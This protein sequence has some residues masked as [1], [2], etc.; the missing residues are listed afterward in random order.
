VPLGLAETAELAVRISLKDDLSRGLTGLTGKINKLDSGLGRAGKGVGQLGAGFARA[1]LLVGGGVITGLT[2][3][4]K[5]GADF[6]AQL[7][8]INTIARESDEGLLRIGDGIRQLAR[9]GRGD[10]ADLSEG[11]YD[12]LSAGVKA[13]DA[14]DVLTAATTLAIG[15]LSTNAEAVDLLTTAINAY[16]QDATAA[17]AD[18]DLFAKAIEIGKVKADEIAASFANVAPI[19]AQTGIN[20]EEVAAAYGALTAQGTPAAEVATQMQRAILDLLNPGKELLDLQKKLNVSFIDIAQEEGLVVALQAMR[21]AVGGDEAAFKALFGRVEGYKFALQTTG[22][23]QEKYNA[24]LRAM[25]DSA[26]TASEQMG[27]RQ[28]GLA[29]QVNKLKANLVDA[30][31]ELSSGFLP[32]LTRSVSTLTDELAKPGTRGSLKAIGEDIGEAI[33][34]IN[35]KEV[36]SGAKEF[37]GVMKG[38]LSFAKQLFDIF[39]ALPT[40]IKAATVGFLALNKLSGGLVG[41]GVG[42]IVG[43]LGETIAKSGASR[44]PGVGK[45]FAQPVF[46]TNWPMGGLGGGG[47]GGGKGGGVRGFIGGAGGLLAAGVAAG[48]AVEAIAIWD[49]TNRNSTEQAQGIRANVDAQIAGNRSTEELK[50]SLAAVETGINQIQANPLLT[51]VQGEALDHLR[52]MQS[53]L[54]TEIT[55]RE[56]WYKAPPG[57]GPPSVRVPP[58]PGTVMK[59]TMDPPRASSTDARPIVSAITATGAAQR[60]ELGNIKNGLA[61]LKTNAA[62]QS[63]AQKAELANIKNATA[64]Q[65]QQQNARAAAQIAVTTAGNMLSVFQSASQALRDAGQ[66]AATVTAGTTAASAS[67]TAGYTVSG[68]MSSAASRIVGAIYAARPIIQ[69]TNVVN[70]YT[71][72][73]RGGVSSDSRYNGGYGSG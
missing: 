11:Y 49:Q 41:A 48:L 9:E 52:S 58:K 40:E 12:I 67:R 22:P 54:K 73:Q 59:P 57:K 13:A 30:G 61:T 53:D 43:G 25:G 32:A 18:A 63:A 28:Q 35:W 55:N 21:D 39:N 69:S 65:T 60:A 23:Q 10:L 66:R 3:A 50:T 29:F 72:T 51:L 62:T 70:N 31:L 33:D 15:G 44:L 47:I 27:E 38:A 64:T 8:T 36:L 46:V 24:A 20:I 71:R 14:Q 2:A 26:G 16:G 17:A 6:E 19:A 42:N 1:G 68:A 37:V 34:D 5:V 45:L 7:R 56:K 4:A